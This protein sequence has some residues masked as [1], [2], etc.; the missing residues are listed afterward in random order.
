MRGAK[1]PGNRQ[2]AAPAG[3]DQR[4]PDE[5]MDTTEEWI[6]QRTGIRERRFV[7][8]GTGT[9]DLGTEA[10]RAAVA[11]AGLSLSDIH[12][13]VFATDLAGSCASRAAGCWSRRSSGSPRSAPST[14]GR[15]A[16]VSSTGYRWPR[17]TSK[18]GS[19]TR[20]RHRLRSPSTGL[21]LSTAARDVSVIFGDGG[22]PRSSRPAEGIRGR[23]SSPPTFTRR[24]SSAKTYVRGALL[25][26]A[27]AYQ[28]RD[29]GRRARISRG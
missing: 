17:P 16:P 4:R 6:V 21:N 22:G 5:C 7:D 18:A 28:P 20:P 8:P 19:S 25:H 11:R 3:G 26:R 14:S 15:S 1:N 24:G 13:L 10:A 29:A 12:F 23:A 27:P 2:G 9:A